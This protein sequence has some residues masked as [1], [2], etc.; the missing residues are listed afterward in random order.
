M[1]EQPLSPRNVR[2]TRP[3]IRVGEQEHA[4]VSELAL[5]LRMTESEGGMSSLELRFSQV[6]SEQSGSA[7]TA[8]FED[9]SILRL[10]VPIKVY[11][12]EEDS[13]QEIFQ[14]KITGIE[15]CFSVDGPPELVVLAEDALT[16]AR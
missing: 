12:G 11:S 3:T 1:T 9:E 10:G 15:A 7:Q 2:P 4:L 14:G 16:R 5:S 13:P 6:A 8:A